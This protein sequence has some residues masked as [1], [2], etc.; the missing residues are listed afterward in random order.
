MENMS[1]QTRQKAPQL[2]SKLQLPMIGTESGVKMQRAPP[3]LLVFSSDGE[4]RVSTLY[5]SAV[6]ALSEINQFAETG[7]Y[8]PSTD[9]DMS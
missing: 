4:R 2:I 6:V 5:P 1:L 8:Y 9:F 3:E 7:L